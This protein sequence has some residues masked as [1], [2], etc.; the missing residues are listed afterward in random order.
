MVSF[1]EYSDYDAVGLAKLIRMREVGAE[2]V[3]EA[4]APDRAAADLGDQS[5][6][7]DLSRQLGQRGNGV[8]SSP[9]MF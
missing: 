5:T 9:S 4:A 3:L 7:D 2:E 1:R 8:S 6:G